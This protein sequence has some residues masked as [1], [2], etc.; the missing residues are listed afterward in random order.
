MP[1]DVTV[2]TG[3]DGSLLFLDAAG[4]E[5][6]FIS[7]PWAIDS[8]GKEVPTSYSVEGTTLVQ[9]VDHEGA[10]YPVLADPS[11]WE[12]AAGWASVAAAAVG[13][14]VCLA[15]VCGAVGTAVAVVSVVAASVYVVSQMIPDNSSGGGQRPSNRCNMRNR[16]GC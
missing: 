15:T 5:A 12:R 7:M 3:E 4:E 2:H 10:S 13:A 8:D 9:T 11:W 1:D 14:G 6:G 16:S